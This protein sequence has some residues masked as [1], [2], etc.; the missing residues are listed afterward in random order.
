MNKKTNIKGNLTEYL[1][2]YANAWLFSGNILVVKDNEILVNK[3]YGYSDIEHN[4][5]NNIDAK[6]NIC[7]LTKAFTAMAVMILQEKSLL[8]LKDKINKHLP[9][10]PEFNK[11]ITIHHLLTH[12]SGI[13]NYNN[14]DGFFEKIKQV[15]YSKAEFV[16]LFK[17]LPLDFNPGTEF[18]Y[19]N[20]GYY[21][22]GLMIEKISNQSYE[23]F[24]TENIFKP[25][26]M[27]NSGIYNECNILKNKANGYE[28]SGDTLRNDS[29]SEWSKF[30]P[31]GGIYSTLEDM[32]KW[33]E[34]LIKQ[35][36]VSKEAYNKI[37]TNHIS[38]Y[39]YG[40][41]IN[42]QDGLRKYSHNGAHNGY[43]N[44][45]NIYPDENLSV[46]LMC[47]Y[48]FANVH[49]ISNNILD[50]VLNNKQLKVSKPKKVDL[51]I[52]QCK[53]YIG[54]YEDPDD[55][56]NFIVSLEN[57][58]M[59]LQFDETNKFEIY[60]ISQ[61]VFNHI[62]IDEQYGFA[63]DGIKVWGDLYKKI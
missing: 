19:S 17:D 12:S 4:T 55:D 37:F 3:S 31:T 7:S 20:S 62:H 2:S 9:E 47:N 58:K 53:K 5:L 38:N 51:S 25:L 54:E 28:L 46:L 50:I 13:S 15:F 52:E 29:F 59:Y 39:G 33:N 57:D 18:R 30:A 48:R 24:I 14:L 42:E 32:T 6:F 26:G 44:Q 41:F 60:P 16:K 23:E 49:D 56:D 40:W 35:T 61:T 8:N 27:N 43:M 45:F 1:D 36:L 11:D 10:Y 34:S 22:L 21:L 63:Q